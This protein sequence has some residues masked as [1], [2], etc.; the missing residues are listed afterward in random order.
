MRNFSPKDNLFGKFQV[1]GVV[2]IHAFPAITSEL[3]HQA[4]I[5]VAFTAIRSKR[6]DDFSSKAGQWSALKQVRKGV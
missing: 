3:A 5:I 1:P 4:T 2:L 6:D